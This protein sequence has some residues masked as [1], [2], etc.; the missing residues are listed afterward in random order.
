M[1]RTSRIVRRPGSRFLSIFA[2]DVERFGLACAGVVALLDFFDRAQEEGGLPTASRARI[3]AEL[4]GLAGRNAVDKALGELLDAGIVSKFEKTKWGQR[5]F[6]RTVTYGL[7]AAAFSA[8][9]QGTPDSG[10][11]GK[12]PNRELREV[13]E[14]GPEQGTPSMYEKEERSPSSAGAGISADDAAQDRFGRIHGIVT[15]TLADREAARAL[16]AE[17]SADELAAAIAAVEDRDKEPLPSLVR[18]ELEK[19]A[20]RKRSATRQKTNVQQGGRAPSSRAV[21]K[22]G[23]QAAKTALAK[24]PKLTGAAQ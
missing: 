4:E 17:V 23:L 13:P 1:S 2:D 9:L 22:A 15:W 12:S 14:S 20:R 7:D 8:L 16:A 5:N 6:I 18:R 3:V 19:M 24:T 11:S 10:S 21:A